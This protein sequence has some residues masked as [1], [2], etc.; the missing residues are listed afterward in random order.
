MRKFAEERQSINEI[1]VAMKSGDEKAIQ[2]AW[3]NFHDSIAA[4]VKADFE[5]LQET[6]DSAVLAQRG[7]RQLTNNEKKWYQKVITA[8]KSADPKQAF[9]SIIGSDNEEDLM[10]TTIIE[11]VYK[12]LQE[13]HPLLKAIN[14]QY[15]GSITKWILNDH[16]AQNAV[17]GTITAEITKEITS[18][19]KVVDINQNKLSAY[20]IV[21]LGMLDLGPVFLDG[22][23][24]AVLAEAIMSGLEL[25]IIAGSGKDEPIGLI[26]DIHEGVSYSSTTG[27]PNKTAEKVT[28]FTPA[29]YGAL[30]AKLA[31][32]EGGKKRKFSKV[33][34]VC[35][36]TDYLTKIMPAT[37]VLTAG[38]TFANNLFPFA[39]DVYVS[40]ALDDG[41]AVMFLPEEYFLGMGGSKN[42]VIE[43]SDEYKFLE[44]QRVFKIKQYGAGR[45][46]D[47]TSALYLDIAD[48]E[49]AYITVKNHEV[50][51]A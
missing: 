23:I 27:Y 25:A 6:H 21:E 13:E 47:N 29:S 49:P 8:L 33:A 5:E 30:V 14:F 28:D 2:T 34:L 7:Y 31:V 15:V 50:V 19:F 44:D 45:A 12:N 43:Y 35:N 26:K 4:E 32:T 20:A 46:F 1:V 40:N 10:P 37:T 42:G 9:T 48:L 22:Y 41:K 39:T 51:T 11:D 38:G 16:S 24:R 17:W 18:S 36:M 3:E